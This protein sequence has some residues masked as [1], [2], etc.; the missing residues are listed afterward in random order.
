MFVDWTMAAGA[1][2]IFFAS[3][4]QTC[5]AMKKP[6][7]WLTV[8]KNRDPKNYARATSAS[9]TRCPFTRAIAGITDRSA[10]DWIPHSVDLESY[11]MRAWG[12][13]FLMLGSWWSAAAASMTALG[14]LD[15]DDFKD[16]VSAIPILLVPSALLLVA[17]SISARPRRKE[18]QRAAR[19]Y[20]RN[21]PEG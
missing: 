4:L 2:L 16:P 17:T 5:D 8:A 10:L 1:W 13:S 7:A 12:W 19:E 18:E 14:R 6:W 21:H 15:Y 9:M 20:E 11:N 3:C